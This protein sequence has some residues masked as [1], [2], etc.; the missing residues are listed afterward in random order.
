MLPTL[1]AAA[2][3]DGADTEAQLVEAIYADVRELLH[4]VARFSVWAHLRKLAADGGPPRATTSTTPTP[5]GGR[6]R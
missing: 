3:P 5:L 1:L 4:P 2:G 6:A